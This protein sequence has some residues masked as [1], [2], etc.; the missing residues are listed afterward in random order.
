M[1]RSPV[2]DPATPKGPSVH[3]SASAFKKIPSDGSDRRFF[4]GRWEGVPAI[5][6]YPA[7]GGIGQ[8]E[9]ASYAQIGRHL[10]KAKVPVPEIFHFDSAS[11]ILVVEDVGDRRLQ[12]EIVP[13]ADK[14][15]I[16]RL[17]R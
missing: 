1:K 15:T 10:R 4:R 14:D 7:P 2:R 5:V 8:A 12:G 6:I 11:G 3:P 13:Q 9:A 17:Y 16:G